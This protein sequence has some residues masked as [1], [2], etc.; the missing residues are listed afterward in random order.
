MVVSLW[1]D[2]GKGGQGGGR[3][4]RGV[5]VAVDFDEFAR[6]RRLEGG[7]DRLEQGLTC[8]RI[9]ERLPRRVQ[10]GNAAQRQ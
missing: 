4:C 9:M 8:G 7:A 1:V 10:R 2:L 5:D 6:G 3:E